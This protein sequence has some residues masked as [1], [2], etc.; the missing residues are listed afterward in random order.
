MLVSKGPDLVTVPSVKG[1]K[2]DEAVAKLEAAGLR[3]GDV[4]G[5]ANGK[6]FETDPPKGSKVKRGSTVNIYLR[7]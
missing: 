2:L 6:P 3:A 5:P 7:R 4:F 1:T